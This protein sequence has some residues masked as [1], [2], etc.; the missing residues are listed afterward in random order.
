[1]V[2]VTIGSYNIHSGVGQDGK[3][4]IHRVGDSIRSFNAD[5]IGVQE[6]EL[7][8]S[9]Q[10]TRIWSTAHKDDQP[11]LIAKA[12]EYAH[13]S[14]VRLFPIH[15]QLSNSFKAPALT[16]L[17]TSAFREHHDTGAGEFGIAIFSKFPITKTITHN[18]E[19]YR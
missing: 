15:L 18:Y 4:N 14:F 6:I 8:A 9:F 12:A 19:I 17:S 16:S 2:H 10:K 3:Y 7:N 13:Y 1:M 5:I 11:A